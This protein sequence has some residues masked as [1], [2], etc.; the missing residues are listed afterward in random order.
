[1]GGILA[2]IIPARSNAEPIKVIADLD[3]LIPAPFG[4]KLGGRVYQIQ[5]GTIRKLAGLQDKLEVILHLLNRATKGEKVPDFDLHK[6]Y[7]QY[8]SVL[9]PEMSME[10]VENMN[11]PQLRRLLSEIQ[12]YATGQSMDP[13]EDEKKKETQEK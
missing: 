10:A 12:K 8:L 11:L 7:H 3:Q 6:A 9:C 4:F 2:K 5:V 13:T 1:M